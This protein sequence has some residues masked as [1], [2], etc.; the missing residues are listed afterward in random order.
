MPRLRI[1]DIALVG[2]SKKCYKISSMARSYARAFSSRRG[3]CFWCSHYIQGNA[4]V[5]NIC[6]AKSRLCLGLARLRRQ[7][8]CNK[9]ILPRNSSI[10]TKKNH[11]YITTYANQ[12]NAIIKVLEGNNLLGKFEFTCI[13]P[14]PE[15]VGECAFASTSTQQEV[16]FAIEQANQW[17][18]SNQLDGDAKLK[19]KM[20]QVADPTIASMH[21]GGKGPRIDEVD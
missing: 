14:A 18:E 2:G 21:S 9:L 10:S 20:K 16:Q 12:T 13:P 8:E 15:G 3:C 5:R 1:H 17:L 7:H 6:Y 19:D 11:I 4:E